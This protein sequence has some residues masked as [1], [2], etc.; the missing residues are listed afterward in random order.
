M[1]LKG[2]VRYHKLSVAILIFLTLFSIIHIT[3]PGLIYNPDGGFRPFGIGYQHKT[4][5][6]IWVVAIVLAILSYLGV[7]YY[8]MFG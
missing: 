7:M 6:P 4:V 1:K 2:I 3:K 5:I 8:L